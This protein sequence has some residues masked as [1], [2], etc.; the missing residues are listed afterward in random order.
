MSHLLYA[1]KP[2]LPPNWY[3]IRLELVWSAPNDPL[4]KLYSLL[5]HI[6]T[7]GLAEGRR[8]KSR[9]INGLFAIPSSKKVYVLSAG[10]DMS[11]K[12]DSLKATT[13][14]APMPSSADQAILSE[15]TIS[16]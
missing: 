13:L 3:K 12:G 9:V 6:K 16:S 7:P 5:Y 10:P 2:N 4:L 14:T 1:R 8:K 11:V 15:P